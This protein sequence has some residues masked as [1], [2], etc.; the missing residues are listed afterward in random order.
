MRLNKKY[1]DIFF[2][3][4]PFIFFYTITLA[5]DYAEPSAE[6]MRKLFYYAETL[7]NSEFNEKIH[8]AYEDGR[9]TKKECEELN[10]VGRR[11]KNKQDEA[12]L[13][14]KLRTLSHE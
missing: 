13:N 6:D 3:L 11:L 10:R 8:Y 9:L 12:V 5:L 1:V 2:I 14:K 7:H 4:L